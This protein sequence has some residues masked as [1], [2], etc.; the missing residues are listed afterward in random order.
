MLQAAKMVM[1]HS[2]FC[3]IHIEH[4]FSGQN[5][6]WLTTAKLGLHCIYRVWRREA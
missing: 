5:S 4:D 1:I 6:P 2:D 3:H